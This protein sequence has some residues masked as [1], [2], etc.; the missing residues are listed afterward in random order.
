[1]S[2]ADYTHRTAVLNGAKILVIKDLNLGNTS[3]TNDIENVVNDIAIM[4][5]INPADYLIIYKDSEGN[6]D[7]WDHAAMDF[8]PLGENSWISA[9]A[10]YKELQLQKS[11]SSI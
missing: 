11:L 2:K 5:S 8:V 3:V 4:E 6:Y 10:K 7:G 9:A 1:M